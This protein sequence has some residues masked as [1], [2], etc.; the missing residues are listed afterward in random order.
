MY[1]KL[2]KQIKTYNYLGM[3]GV[4]TLQINAAAPGLQHTVCCSDSAA[5]PH[6][7][8]LSTF[9]LQLLYTALAI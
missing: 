9:E 7:G 3:I 1:T 2:I 5:L 8:V 6:L 4:T